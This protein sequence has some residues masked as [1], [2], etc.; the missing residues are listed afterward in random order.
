MV[1]TLPQL[2]SSPAP[3]TSPVVTQPARVSLSGTHA[4][5]STTTTSSF[6]TKPSEGINLEVQLPVVQSL[7]PGA[8]IVNS[9][10][11]HPQS[12]SVN[13][14]MLKLLPVPAG[15][16]PQAS[17]G[18]TTLQPITLVQ[19]QSQE[20]TFHVVTSVTSPVTQTV[21]LVTSGETS[22]M[23]PIV[24][25][26]VADIPDLLAAA[27]QAAV[28]HLITQYPKQ[29]PP[30]QHTLQIDKNIAPSQ[31]KIIRL[32]NE[33][34]QIPVGSQSRILIVNA[35]NVA[36]VTS[37]VEA[38]TTLGVVGSTNNGTIQST[39]PVILDTKNGSNEKQTLSSSETVTHVASPSSISDTETNKKKTGNKINSLMTSLCCRVLQMFIN[40]KC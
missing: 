36:Q 37:T 10:S 23:R 12:V 22:S 6:S 39:I 17:V 32:S 35:P 14:K 19:S 18:A 24:K 27:T 29:L 15:V 8:Q 20:Q 31:P 34:S 3:V 1:Y 26:S 4:N 33:S 7:P 5:T 16:K 40:L 9:F 11:A 28:P 21:T 38:P 13:G 25:S 30:Q 2:I